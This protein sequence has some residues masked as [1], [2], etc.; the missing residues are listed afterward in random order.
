MK[1]FFK[2][3]KADIIILSGLGFVYLLTRLIALL[4]L[5]IFT[6][7]SIYIYWAKF[8]DSYHSH[9]LISIT[10]GKPPLL[11]WVLTTGKCLKIALMVKKAPSNL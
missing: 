8:I 10:D 5:P 4:K 1:N 7:E 6:D 3:H 11:I 9:W 2:F